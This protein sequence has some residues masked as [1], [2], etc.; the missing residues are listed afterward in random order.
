LNR[1]ISDA[2]NTTAIPGNLARAEG[3]LPTGILDVDDSY[4]FLGDTYGFYDNHHNRDSY[5]G[6]GAPLD[7]TVRLCVNGQ[8]C[9]WPNAY[10]SSGRTHFG[11]GWAVDDV[12]A[13][14]LTHGVT[15]SESGLIYANTSGAINES[16]SDIWGEFVDLAN[17]AGN[18]APVVRWL[19]GEDLAIGAIRHMGNPPAFGDPDR[20]GS[21]LYVPPTNN[22]DDT[23]DYGGVHTNSGVSNRLCSLLTDGGTF[24]GWTI[25]AIGIDATASLFYD[26]NVNM[27]TPGADW[28]DLFVALQNAAQPW[29]DEERNNIFRACAAVEI[30]PPSVFPIYV[31]GASSCPYQTGAT[32]CAP[33]VFSGPFRTVT[34]AVEAVSPGG[35]IQIESGNYPESLVIQKIATV[36]A[37]GGPVTIGP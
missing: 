34:Q 15:E 36:V 29:S 26:A 1:Q 11:T 32:V 19:V 28:T 30:N 13:H 4:D 17:G 2:N 6:S 37:V 20:L 9:P 22:P 7:A 14:E 31:N 3:Q 25:T 27:L 33:Q 24:N 8:Q 23:N 12:V 5:D 10:W 21:P 18:D 16:F 35:L